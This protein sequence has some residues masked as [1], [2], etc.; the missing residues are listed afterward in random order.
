LL[1]VKIKYYYYCTKYHRLPMFVSSGNAVNSTPKMLNN[2]YVF[3][4]LLQIKIKKKKSRPL[5]ACHH[6]L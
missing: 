3:Y 6:K 1:K 5:R 2:L 4:L